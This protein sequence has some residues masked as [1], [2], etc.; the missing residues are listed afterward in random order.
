MWAK[1][2]KFSLTAVWIKFLPRFQIQILAQKL[3]A[4]ACISHGFSIASFDYVATVA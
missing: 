1:E 4:M 2:L 3:S